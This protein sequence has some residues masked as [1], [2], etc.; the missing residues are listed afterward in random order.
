MPKVPVGLAEVA[1]GHMLS[2]LADIRQQEQRPRQPNTF[3]VHHSPFF[4]APQFFF[5]T[6][7]PART[8]RKAYVLPPANV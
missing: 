5:L 2:V 8:S 6:E 4:Q 3:G 7:R 1:A